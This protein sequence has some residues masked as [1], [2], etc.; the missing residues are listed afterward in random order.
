VN[1]VS[2]EQ[3]SNEQVS[4]EW[5][6]MNWSQLS[7][8]RTDHILSKSIMVIWAGRFVRY[9]YA[10]LSRSHSNTTLT[11]AHFILPNWPFCG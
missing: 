10:S 4:N 8:R 11:P 2:N 6:Q 1:L 5:S 3:V 9:A 7:A